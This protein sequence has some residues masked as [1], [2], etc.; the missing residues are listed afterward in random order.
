MGRVEFE[1][2]GIERAITVRLVKA[3][4]GKVRPVIIMM[5]IS[6]ARYVSFRDGVKGERVRECESR[7][8]DEPGVAMGKGQEGMFVRYIMQKQ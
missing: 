7:V 5:Y 6:R 4:G 8:R 2:Y 3:S 1:G